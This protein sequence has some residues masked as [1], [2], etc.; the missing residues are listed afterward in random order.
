MDKTL[1]KGGKPR[2][3]EAQEHT[4]ENKLKKSYGFHK[5]LL[6][7]SFFLIVIQ[8][9]IGLKGA[10]GSATVWTDGQCGQPALPT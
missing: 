10:P 5:P 9:R 3:L 1:W 7:F 2:P 6:H 4:L 8:A